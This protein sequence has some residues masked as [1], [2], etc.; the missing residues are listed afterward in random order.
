MITAFIDMVGLLMVI[1]ILPFYAK[2]LGAGGLIVGMLV[3]SFAVAQLLTAPM[4]GRLS[5][6][7]GRRASA[8]PART[9]A[10][11]WPARRA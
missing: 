6:A 10:R 11:P 2:E 1:P 7:Y 5:D 3:S 4:W 9:A 8:T